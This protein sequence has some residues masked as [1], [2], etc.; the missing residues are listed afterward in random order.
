[1]KKLVT[2]KTLLQH[3]V[4]LAAFL[5]MTATTLLMR[6]IGIRRYIGLDLP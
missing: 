2:L 5:I 4:E 1:M 6:S 3:L